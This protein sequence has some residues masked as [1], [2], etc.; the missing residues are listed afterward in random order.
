MNMKRLQMYASWPLENQALRVSSSK[1]SSN[2]NYFSCNQS[3][4]STASKTNSNDSN[5]EEDIPKS[6]YYCGKSRHISFIAGF[7]IITHLNGYGDPKE[8]QVILSL[9]DLK[10]FG[11]LKGDDD[12][13]LQEHHKKSKGK[14]YLD[15]ECSNHM[16]GDKNL[17]KS[18]AD[19]KGGNIRFSDNSKGIVIGIASM[20]DD[21]WIWHKKLG[22]ASIRLIEKLAKNELVIRLPKLDYSKD[23]ICDACQM[24]KQTMIIRPPDIVDV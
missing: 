24:G 21:P 14:W 8:L 16:T 20:T 2:G 3:F 15:S 10:K 19:F 11:Y 12:F 7:V 9:K 23:H 22:H 1:N 6:Y 17:F 5:S 18:V 13:V 4:K